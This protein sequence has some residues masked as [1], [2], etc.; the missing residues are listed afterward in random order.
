MNDDVFFA[1]SKANEL[2]VGG[3]YADAI[4]Y[5]NQAIKAEPNSSELY[6]NRGLSF[7]HLENYDEALQDLSKAIELNPRFNEAHY[8]RGLIYEYLHD[9]DKAKE[10]Y[11]A[12]VV[13]DAA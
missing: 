5:F 6:Y 3:S 1:V 7:I 13:K 9:F 4:S 11:D 10:D 12:V 2:Y 8:S